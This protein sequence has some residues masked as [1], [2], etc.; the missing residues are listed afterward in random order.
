MSRAFHH[1]N[2]VLP[3]VIGI[4][5][6][7]ALQAF[8]ADTVISGLVK[9][10]QNRVI[11]D[12]IITAGGKERAPTETDPNGLF[13]LT[14][15][16]SS[17]NIILR[18]ERKGFNSESVPVAA[19]RD[20][21]WP[22]TLTPSAD[23]PRQDTMKSISKSLKQVDS[24]YREMD[25]FNTQAKAAPAPPYGF[26]LKA[27]LTADQSAVEFRQDGNVVTTITSAD[28]VKLS[29]GSQQLIA[30]REQSMTR[31]F[32]TWTELYPKLSDPSITNAER[33]EV[34]DKLK[35]TGTKMCTDLFGILDFLS[36][37]NIQL[38]DHYM[39]VRNVC[40]T[41]IQNGGVQGH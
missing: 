39:S 15:K 22:I 29:P 11:P 30:A 9:D 40:S 20:T 10:T 4:F 12:V 3:A 26:R 18:A 28:L 32:T 33:K 27:D 5:L 17:G 13:T 41:F 8:G 6:A 38:Y 14:L 21:V 25:M 19:G 7:G 1:V 34:E 24:F 36:T 2:P 35:L 31:Y 16:D 37:M 23:P